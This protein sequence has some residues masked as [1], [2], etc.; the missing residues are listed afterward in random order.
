MSPTNTIADFFATLEA[1]LCAAVHSLGGPSEYKPSL[2]SVPKAELG[3]AAL[4]CF[5][6]K[7]LLTKLDERARNNPGAIAQALATA[8]QAQQLE[9]L[10]SCQAAGPYVNLRYRS[11]AIA[12][13]VMTDALDNGHAFGKLQRDGCH[14]VIEFSAP[15]TNKPQHLGHVRNNVLGE[16]VSRILRH[17]GY[18]VS[19][20]N[21]VNDRGI[22]ICKSMLAYQ[23][24]GRDAT[25]ESTGKK[26]D[27]LIGEFYVMFE[28]AF[29]KEYEAWRQSPDAAAAYQSWTLEP[30][31]ARA[32]AAWE[33]YQ[34]RAA[35]PTDAQTKRPAR[36]PAEPQSVF[37]KEYK[38][39]Y[40]NSLSPLGQQARQLL[41]RW[42]AGDE[43]VRKLWSKLNAWVLEGF[44]DTYR[45]MG[46]HFDKVYY[47]SQTYTLG[48]AAIA[49]GLRS[50]VFYQR[51]DGAI[52]FEL[53]RIGL[54]GEKIVLRSDGTSVYTTQDLGTALARLDELGFDRM[55]YVVADEQ[56]HHFRV[57][58][59]ILAQLRPQ[60]EGKCEHLS[61]GLVHLPS[62]R[63]KSR[64]G[65]VVDAD[66][67]MNEMRS[68]ASGVIAQRMQTE[69]YSQTDDEERVYRAERI[70][71][72]ALKYY[73]LDVSPQ[74]SMEF[75]PEKSIDLQ[76][77]TGAYCLMSYARTR[78]LLRK[79]GEVPELDLEVLSSLSS[80]D[81]K[82]VLLQLLQ[83]PSVVEWAASSRDPS[84]IA[85]Y[86]F[87]LCKAFA[88]VFTDRCGHP[89]INCP[90]PAQ[91]K[92]RLLLVRALGVTL[93]TALGLLGIE[94]I[95][96][97]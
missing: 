69:H 38:D 56:N 92:A 46:I 75:D 54:E 73:L 43:E 39:R 86:L 25:P 59:G 95:E 17:A 41:Q 26:G 48:K 84:R 97:M 40:F 14:V 93:Q 53:S 22:H 13:V 88:F 11:E 51:D 18:K 37:A 87:E 94:T 50:G 63:M 12:R 68:L 49:E 77:R 15:N 96:E 85:E 60:L 55:V 27:H 7:G 82:R 44:D 32:V 24:W 9:L 21:L 16:S 31:G 52:A 80:P 78:S 67:L 10:E 20:V 28:T 5:P 45:R 72:A 74:S 57:L 66:D 71:L 35:L 1:G 36:P 33:K 70:G 42:E 79:A 90:D 8:I 30:S 91:R 4:P 83:W 81:E 34:Q 2:G 19:K 23:L 64:E 6:L 58:F 29:S 3:D 65:T 76:G 47:E 62:G 61:Y 89:I